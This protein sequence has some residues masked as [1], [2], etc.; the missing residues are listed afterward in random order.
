MIEEHAF[1]THIDG[2]HITV[3][4]QVKS[5]CGSCQQVDNCGS[6]Q[7]AKAIPQKKLSLTVTSDMP[8]KLGDKVVIGIL[9]KPLFQT[10]WQVYLLPIIGLFSF[11]GTGQLVSDNLKITHEF[12]TIT[13]GVLGGY[14][15]IKLAQKIESNKEH[16]QR[17]NAKLLKVL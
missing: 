1:V 17:L 9:E 14:L 16:S 4:S 11:A 12:Y 6:G 3:E 7:V 10:A 13:L 2:Q 15:G 8:V 5:A